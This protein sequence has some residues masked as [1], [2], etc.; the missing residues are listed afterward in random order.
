MASMDRGITVV[1][2]SLDLLREV[3][4]LPGSYQVIDWGKVRVAVRHW[5]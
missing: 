4:D 2:L 1:P 5:E 3:V